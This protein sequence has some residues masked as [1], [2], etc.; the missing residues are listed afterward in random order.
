M[1]TADSVNALL[2]G[3]YWLNERVDEVEEDTV[4]LLV[5]GL[6]QRRDDGGARAR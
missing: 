1:A 2:P 3:F 4:E 6:E 5:C